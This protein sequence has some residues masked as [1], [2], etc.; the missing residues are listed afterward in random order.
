MMKLKITCFIVLFLMVSV[1]LLNTDNF[2]VA[3]SLEDEETPREVIVPLSSANV[4]GFQEGSIY[5]NSTL[6]AGGQHTCAILDDG[7]V[8]CWGS[9]S[10]GQLGDGT[11]TDRNTPTQ[12]L[13]LGTGR[14]AVALSS[15]GYHTCAILDDGTVSCWGRNLAGGLG[16]GTTTQRNTPTQTSSLGTGRTAV[17]ISSGFY[18]TCAILDDGSVSCW[19]WNYFG[20]LGDGTTTDR[21]TSTQISS[22]GTGRTAIAITSGVAHTCAI[23]DDGYV[24]CWGNGGNGRLGNGGTSSLATPTLTSSLGAN[25]TAVAISSG[26]GF[27]CAIL[28][29]G[30]VSCWGYGGNGR[31]GNGT[32]TD[33][34]TPTQT[35]T[36]GTGRTT[37]AISSGS[38]FTCAILDNNSV[39][40]WGENNRGQ[41][42]DGTTTHRYDPTQA[43]GLGTGRTAVAIYPGDDHT[44]AILDDGTVSC[45]GWN[46]YGQL[47][48]GTTTQRTTPTQTSSL[49]TTTNTRTAAVSERDFDDDGILNIFDITPNGVIQLNKPGFQE[50]SIFTDASLTTGN[51]HTC[52]IL[53]NGS[54]ACWGDNYWGT[55]GNGDSGVNS[56]TTTPTLTNSFGVGRTA[57]ALSSASG[58]TCA[59]LDNGSV[60]CWGDGS[61]GRLGNGVPNGSPSGIISS[62]TLTSSLGIGRT[63]VAISSG[64]THTCAILDNG[65]VSCWGSNYHGQLGDGTT[66]NRNTPTQ[67]LSLGTG[68]TAVSISSGFYS[69]CAILDNGAV[70]CWGDGAYGQ[71]GNGSTSDKNTP[72]LIS[73]LGTNQTAVALSSGVAT[74]CAILDN[75]SVSCW[76]QNYYGGI[77]DG[78]TTDRNTPTLTSS[79]GTNRTAVALS[80]GL[81]N[82]C[83]ILDNGSASCW[84]SNNDGQ[85]GNGGTSFTMIPTLTSSLGIG[86]TAV[87]ISQGPSHTCAILDNG[88]TSCWGYGGYGQLG[89]GGTSN[90][91]VPTLTNSLGANHTVALSERDFDGDGILNIFDG[92]Q[93]L[94]IREST[95]SSGGSHTCA[96]LD[97]GSVS[98]W[99]L[100]SGGQLG[101][102]ATTS[103]T[104]PTLTSSLGAGRTAVALSSGSDHTC[105]LLDNGSISCWGS[106][107]SGQLGNGATSDKSTPTLTSSLGTGRTAVAI[108]SGASHTCAILDNGSVSCWGRGYYGQLGSGSQ[109][110]AADKT[111][112][113]LTS[114]LGTGRTAVALSSGSNHVCAILDNG[115]VSC[116][117]SGSEGQL[118]NGAASD[119]STPT[120]T[121]SLGINRT[122]ID[123]SSGRDYTCALLDNGAVSCWGSG[124][125]GKLGNGGAASQNIPTLTSSLG[126]GRTAVS[127]SSG[128][129]HTCALLDNGA[130]S[131]WGEGGAGEIGNGG[132]STSQNSPTLT[133]SLGVGRTAVAISSGSLFTCAILDNG[134]ASCWGS[135]PNGQLGNGG[136]SNKNTPKLISSLGTN[137]T[138]LFVD[139]DVDGDGTL[140]IFDDFPNNPIRSISCNP[141]QYGRYLCVDSPAGKYVPA[142][143]AMYATDAPAGSYVN[144]TGQSNQTPCSAGT[145]Q[146]LTG[147]V[148]C[149][150]ADAGY[151]V[152][153]S[154]GTGQTSQTACLAGTY[155]PSTGSMNSSACGDAAA[156][157]YVSSMGQSNQTACLAGTY[158]ILTGQTTCDDADA[159][160]YASSIGQSNQTACSAGTYQALTGQVTCDDAEAGYYVSQ[161]AQTNQSECGLGSYQPLIGQSFCDDAD[162]GYYVVQLAQINQTECGLGTYQPLTGQSSCDDADAGY[163]VD[164]LAQLN[165]SE[166]GLGTYQPLTGQSSCDDA[167]AG[168]YVDQMA[169]NNQTECVLGTYQA[170]SG[171]S[172]CDD[173][174]AGYYVEQIAQTNQTECGLGT[175][176]SLIG[177]SSCD[178]ADAGYYADQTA[179]TNQTECGLGTYQSLT[180]QSSCDDAD[181]GY[182]VDQTAQ[183]NQT[184]CGLGT[185]Q[186]LIGQS[187]CDD[188]DAGYYVDQNAQ[189]NQTEC[190]LGTYQSLPGQSS[191]DDVNAG[192]YASQMAQT[193]QT[194]CG[195]GTYQSLTGQSFCDDA[196]AGYYVDQTAQTN[197][198]ECVLGTYQSLIG[199]SSCDDADA[200]YYTEQTAQ[201]NQT[202][203]GLGT[204]Q[205]LT[206]Q[207]SC[208]DSDSGHFVSTTGQ[209][210][211]TECAIG[212]YQA[213]SGQ[214][215]CDD[216]D[217]GYYVDSSLGI[218]QTNQTACLAGTYN[219][220]TGSTNSFACIDADTGSYVSTTGQSNQTAC[221][222]GTYQATTGQSSCVGADTGYYVDQIGQSNQT[223]CPIYT[224][225]LSNAS[226]SIAACK[227]DTDLDN[228]PDIIDSDDDNDGTIDV[229]DAL[230]LD[231]SEDKDTDGDGVGDNLQAKLEAKAQ[232]QMLMGGGTGILLIVI[233][234]LIF[235]K[236][237]KSLPESIKE[238]PAMESDVKDTS[239]IEVGKPSPQP[240]TEA[241]GVIGDDG[242]EWITFPPNS[243]NHFYRAPGDETWLPW[244][245]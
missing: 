125:N 237:K 181:A 195:L 24:S 137:R 199:Q 80:V 104:T 202:E 22:L 182:Y 130:V 163:Y 169:Q 120:L 111:I 136:T 53:D 57:V 83:A 176:Q 25:R 61:Y 127:I 206:G 208:D 204:Y 184:E 228:I 210:S 121:S 63:A 9:N 54:V 123:I 149:D 49:G 241:Q 156:G 72:T 231:D 101:N 76:G 180:G 238:V 64:G 160:Y 212:T 147:Q 220:I 138:V 114:S 12:T 4:P 84:G 23:L 189:T 132:T 230:P 225:T 91:T 50:G 124:G 128:Y 52:V 94:D 26:G 38:G 5:T 192:Y 145:Y 43:S 131:C 1:N 51:G 95:I 170:L 65:L 19:G 88:S 86:R 67:T 116:W 239:T 87:A 60:S 185:Y 56:S 177:Q 21:N 73:S 107:G 173:A 81:Y 140:D 69:T 85:I 119:K 186:S 28:D 31:L 41:L 33:R 30:S 165:Q 14:T 148:T 93:I 110:S 55:L 215:S 90:I 151:Y 236:R 196:D 243:Q 47:G 158:Q 240:S 37:V 68:R 242:Y 118:G 27:T 18:H 188:A 144:Q 193:N 183:T 197:Q 141:G 58:H 6:S 71:L 133:S 153:S 40:C 164:Q 126:T 201:T 207:S 172:S 213:L 89:N 62:P 223:V 214:T 66:I 16:E 190:G 168:Y 108:S 77:G 134:S 103:K 113:T 179:Q 34:N 229:L 59:I 15:G 46:Y 100:G 122:A 142:S 82:T 2:S 17:A 45:W 154:L 44:C 106:G 32:T 117:G 203:C 70:S 194:E 39:S 36:F 143:S 129:S 211:Q 191:C 198:T 150:N 162:A 102:G 216:A 97:N 227:L 245:N 99:G 96:I 155:N 3:E 74:T 112:P 171:Q 135:N 98:C 20:Q 205:S 13:S 166:C 234:A 79:L 175:Y 75:G 159:G 222:L 35:S 152:D 29:D 42:G 235:F 200:G 174:D 161:M 146:A 115:S 157:Y 7:S 187:S 233:G 217:A 48:D 218:A 139:G 219:P 11:Y 105:A 221:A 244:E 78:T 232:T 167:D 178:N 109:G 10:Y 92:H 8:S 224:S 226:Q 209:S